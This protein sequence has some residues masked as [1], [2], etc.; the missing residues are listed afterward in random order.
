MSGLLIIKRSEGILNYLVNESGVFTGKSKTETI[1]YWLSDIE[2]WCDKPEVCF[3]YKD[4]TFEVNKLFIIWNFSW[5]LQAR[6]ANQSARYIGYKHKPF[7]KEFYYYNL[8]AT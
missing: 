4:R 8:R 2:V 3:F 7:K 5:F 6:K 1:T